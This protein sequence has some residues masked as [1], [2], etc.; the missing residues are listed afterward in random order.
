MEQKLL[1]NGP[2]HTFEWLTSLLFAQ[3][4]SLRSSNVQLLAYTG[5]PDA[6]DWLEKNIGSPV[7]THWGEAAALLG[8]DWDRIGKWLH[9]EK[10]HILMALDALYACRPP[11][12]NMSALAQ[13]AAPHLPNP[14]SKRELESELNSVLQANPNPRMRFTIEGIMEHIDELVREN[15][16]R[17]VEVV[18]MPR[19]FVAPEQFPGAKGIL[20]QH[21]SVI[22]KMREV[23]NNLVLDRF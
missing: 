14:P 9:G 2:S 4:P 21:L 3:R 10:P 5:H 12:P 11:A 6:I 7:T 15:G 8:A 22:G 18:D 19:L 16:V 20:S 17:G 13:I 1:D 23:I